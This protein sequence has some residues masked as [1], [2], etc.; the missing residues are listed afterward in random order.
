MTSFSRSGSGF[1]VLTAALA[2]LTG[3]EDKNI[4]NLTVGIPRDSVI[5]VLAQGSP[6]TDST[7]NVYREERYLNAGHF[8]TMLMYSSTGKK[9][10]EQTIPEEE[11]IPVVL[12]NDT[13]TGWGWEHH[14]SVATANNIV[15][16][17]RAK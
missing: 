8:I 11:L 5:K 7:P 12:V 1:I 16:K 6:A 13:L 14:D 10:A 3:C 4:R 15:I 9:E 2:A 17:P